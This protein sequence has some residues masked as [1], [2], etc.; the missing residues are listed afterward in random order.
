MVLLR[1]PFCNGTNAHMHAHT[2]RTAVCGV[3][4]SH[5]FDDTFDERRDDGLENT[6]MPKSAKFR[7]AQSDKSRVCVNT[8]VCAHV[9]ASFTTCPHANAHLPPLALTSKSASLY[10]RRSSITPLSPN[11]SP[12]PLLPQCSTATWRVYPA[13]RE[14]ADSSATVVSARV[15]MNLSGSHIEG[16]RVS[17]VDLAFVRR[18]GLDEGG[19]KSMSGGAE[20]VELEDALPMEV[21]GRV[22]VTI[23]ATLDASLALAF[24]FISGDPPSAAW[25]LASDAGSPASST[26]S[27]PLVS[28]RAESE[29]RP[30]GHADGDGPGRARTARTKMWLWVTDLKCP[31][32]VELGAD[33]ARR[34]WGLEREEV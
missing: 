6:M 18:A 11:P 13:G 7:S 1:R 16:P 19:R 8:P 3:H 32:D 15:C 31:F 22:E 29:E 33:W 28:R 14:A 30:D 4:P 27:L 9:D 17:A 34:C 12:L 10:S 21:Y 25:D 20:R 23:T 5:P 26:C 24:A 2:E